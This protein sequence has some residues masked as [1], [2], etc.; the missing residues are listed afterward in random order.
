MEFNG[1]LVQKL[2]E[3]SGTS[4]RGSWRIAKFLLREITAFPRNLVVD[5]RDDSYGKIEQFEG[6][7]GQNVTVDYEVSAHVF[8]N[9]TTGV[10]SWINSVKAY[11]IK[12]LIASAAPAPAQAAPSPAPA[13]GNQVFEQMAQEQPVQNAAGQQG[14][15]QADTG[16]ASQEDDLPW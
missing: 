5:V 4:E 14:Q 7:I 13:P 11:R 1:Q 10:E 16:V 8:K 12:A 3:Q 6:Y 2:G 15:G 9:R